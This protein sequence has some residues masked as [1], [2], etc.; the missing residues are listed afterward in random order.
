[1]KHFSARRYPGKKDLIILLII[2]LAGSSLGFFSIGFFAESKE[3]C[4]TSRGIVKILGDSLSPLAEDSEK[5]AVLYGYY[6]CH[7]VRR[8]DIIL[9]NYS[10]SSMP[11]IKIVFAV[12]GDSL[13]F[14]PTDDGGWYIEINSS[15]AKNSLGQSYGLNQNSHELL[16]SYVSG[17]NGTIP[18]DAFLILGNKLGPAVDSRKFG[19]VDRSD[20]L[21]KVVLPGM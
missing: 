18:K 20:I 5:I 15:L 14:V 10:G 2:V 9:Y 3:D 16:D 4:V 12:P 11:I 17:N 6:A 13:V 19:L 7:D 1:M 21:G 8:G